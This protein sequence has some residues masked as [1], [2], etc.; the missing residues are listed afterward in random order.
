MCRKRDSAIQRVFRVDATPRKNSVSGSCVEASVVE[1]LCG[2]ARVEASRLSGAGLDCLCGGVKRQA[3]GVR[4]DNKFEW[5]LWG[6][7]VVDDVRVEACADV[8]DLG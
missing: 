4:R 3:G 7:P 2:A 6:R 5:Q 1:A 8:S